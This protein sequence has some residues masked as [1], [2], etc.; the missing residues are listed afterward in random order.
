MIRPN[1]DYATDVPESIRDFGPL[2]EFYDSAN[3]SGG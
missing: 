3:H 2:H 1:H